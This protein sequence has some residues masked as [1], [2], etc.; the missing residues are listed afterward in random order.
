MSKLETLAALLE[1]LPETQEVLRD[2]FEENP[3]VATLGPWDPDRGSANITMRGHYGALSWMGNASLRAYGVAIPVWEW[4]E[5]H[6]DGSGFWVLNF[7]GGEFDP[8]FLDEDGVP[9]L[10]EEW[11]EPL[12][13][14]PSP[15]DPDMPF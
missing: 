3:S 2:F 12:P 8:I 9:I 11:F 5:T 13:W 15:V 14:E 6:P 4:H 10:G 1:G 7:P